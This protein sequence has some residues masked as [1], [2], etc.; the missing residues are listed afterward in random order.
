MWSASMLSG[1][2][3]WTFIVATG[4]MVFEASNS[5][6]WVGIITFSSMVP[7]LLVSPLAGLLG[8]SMDRKTLAVIMMTASTLIVAVMAVLATAGVIEL[9]HVAVLAFALGCGR[10]FEGLG[11]PIDIGSVLGILILEGFL[12]TTLDTAIRL[13]RYLLEELWNC[14]F[15]GRVPAV[16]RWRAT[17]TLLAVGGML[18]F[19]FSALYEQIWPIFGSGNQLIG[20]L[21]LTTVTVWLIQRGKS[22]WFVAIPAAFMVITTMAA[23]WSKMLIDAEAAK[24]PLA[25]AGAFLFALAIGFVVVGGWRIYQALRAAARSAGPAPGPD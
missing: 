4:W 24:Y 12:I 22:W 13:C 20:A 6:G 17:N 11:V 19:A 8:D 9:W 15:A 5:S 14:L 1:A 18:A 23:L 10:L 3:V 2:A 7:F 25:A 16:L 21:A